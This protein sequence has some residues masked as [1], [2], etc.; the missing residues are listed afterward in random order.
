MKR[1]SRLKAVLAGVVLAFEK[2]RGDARAPSAPIAREAE[3]ETLL[4]PATSLSVIAAFRR[5]ASMVG[6]R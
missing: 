2:P 6:M 3:E 5:F 1:P 4:S